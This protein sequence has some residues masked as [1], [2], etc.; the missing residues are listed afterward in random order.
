MGSTA[1][2]IAGAIERIAKELDEREIAEML[3]E[4]ER[5]IAGAKRETEKSAG[6][7]AQFC[8]E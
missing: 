4:A 2:Y 5:L 7:S 3:E 8:C 6:D 1:A